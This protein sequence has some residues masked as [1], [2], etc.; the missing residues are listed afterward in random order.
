[1]NLVTFVL[2]GAMSAD[3]I[4]WL[5]DDPEELA[6]RYQEVEIGTFELIRRHGVILDWGTGEL[7]PKTTG[8]FRAMLK[9]PCPTGRTATRAG[10]EEV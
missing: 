9:A 4:G 8:G 7:L 2:Y 5:D 10:Q 6:R 1:M 3:R